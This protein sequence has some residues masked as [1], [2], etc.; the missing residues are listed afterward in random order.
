MSARRSPPRWLAL[1]LA[2]LVSCTRGAERERPPVVVIAVDGLEWSV[3]LP[4]LQEGRAP[5][6]AALAARGRA[7]ALRTLIPTH[8]P[9]L[10]TS[11]ATGAMPKDHGILFFLEVDP[12]TFQTTEGALPY[13]SN[14]RRVPAIWN[15][16]GE[17][18]RSVLSVG[19]WVS[20]PAEAVP[21]GRIV[22]SYAAQAQADVLWKAGVW[23]EGLEQLTYPPELQA[24]IL[25]L[26]AAGAPLG[27][28]GAIYRGIF[29]EVPEGPVWALEQAIDRNLRF[30]YHSDR[31][32]TQIFL[33]QLE[34]EVADLNLV[35]VGLADVA[36]HFFWRYREPQAYAY[37]VPAEKV[38]RFGTHLERAYV[39]V[40]RWIGE[41]LER[42]PEDALVLV[43]SDHGMHADRLDEPSHFASGG[44]QDGPLGVV[45]A[46]GPG[47]EPGGL[48][49]SRPKAEMT[50]LDVFPTLLAWLD[51]PVPDDAPGEA[52]RDW[53]SA[54]WRAE[55]PEQTIP[56]YAGGFRPATRPRAP[57]GDANEAFVQGMRA[58]GYF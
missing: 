6:L 33:A 7:A 2:L 55:H 16:C 22:A 11:V 13:T 3:L 50:I 44:H 54:A 36:G 28:L 35:Y 15:I 32:H 1:A 25:P 43:V 19:W 24:E 49:T 40:D 10:W 31:T 37:T 23:Q 9:V 30:A 51:L 8:S 12:A 46:A 20:W 48:P 56:S 45:I 42:V 58:L 47:V 5:H 27:P 26:L 29:G 18:G 14:C 34:R 57:L 21:G 53:M 38:E 17:R 4:L 39:E 41:V 52:R